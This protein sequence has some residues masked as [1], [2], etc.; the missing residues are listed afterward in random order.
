MQSCANFVFKVKIRTLTKVHIL[1]TQLMICIHYAVTMA[2]SVPQ[3][4]LWSNHHFIGLPTF[5]TC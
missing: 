4:I 1:A 5:F 3:N 2:C